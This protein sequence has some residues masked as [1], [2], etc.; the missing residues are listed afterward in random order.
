MSILKPKVV[1]TTKTISFRV[2]EELYNDLEEVKKLADEKG[3]VF[4][5]PSIL[6]KTLV[7]SV[8]SART[9]LKRLDKSAAS[10]EVPSAAKQ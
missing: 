3:L 1:N 6:E 5:L 9:E 2:S 8:K 10:N 4:D 7:A